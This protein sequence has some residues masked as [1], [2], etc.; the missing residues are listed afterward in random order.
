MMKRIDIEY[1][2]LN[3]V[4]GK[5]GMIKISPKEAGQE[6]WNRCVMS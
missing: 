1:R 5:I 3:V 2:P 4:E 6:A